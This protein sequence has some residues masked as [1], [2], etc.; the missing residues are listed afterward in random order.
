MSN[1]LVRFK[2][3][4]GSPTTE[5]IT[6][7]LIDV[8]N[9]TSKGTTFAGANVVVKGTSISVGQ[10]ALIRDGEII[11]KMPSLTVTEVGV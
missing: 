9:G 8:T 2:K 11:R 4:I 3:L 7:T 1:A 10:N 5:V 6:I